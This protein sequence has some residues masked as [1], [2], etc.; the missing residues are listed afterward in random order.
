[1]QNNFLVALNNGWNERLSRVID[2]IG[3]GAEQKEIQHFWDKHERNVNYQLFAI[4]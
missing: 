1:M 4:F 2:I 3:G